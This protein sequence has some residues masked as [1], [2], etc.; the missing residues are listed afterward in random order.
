MKKSRSVFVVFTVIL[1]IMLVYPAIGQEWSK[2]QKEVWSNVE[3]YWDIA[4][5]GDVA[6]FLTYFHDSFVGW[7]GMSDAPQTKAQRKK[8]IEYGFNTGETVLYTITPAAIWVKGNFAFAHYY[9]TM[10]LK[11]KEGK[12][13]WEAG[14]WTDIL[15]KDGKKWVMVGDRG[16][17]NPD[18]D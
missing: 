13:K 7:N 1:T 12:E 2:E 17:E 3:A 10:L 15:M 11:D 8:F 18:E 6:G 4:A 16:G 14:R 9:Y 5:K